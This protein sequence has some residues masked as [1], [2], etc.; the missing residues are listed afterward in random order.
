MSKHGL[1]WIT[2]YSQL[3]IKK[4]E[5]DKHLVRERDGYGHTE[6]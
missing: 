3:Q 1:Q 6:L 4:S 5:G 2:V